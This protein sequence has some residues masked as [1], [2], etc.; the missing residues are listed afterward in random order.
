MELYASINVCKM[1][2]SGQSINLVECT[3]EQSWQNG[4]LHHC[5]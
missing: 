5:P 2:A 1:F 4:D 3:V